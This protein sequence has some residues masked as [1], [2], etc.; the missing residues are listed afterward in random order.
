MLFRSKIYSELMDESE[1]IINKEMSNLNFS[2]LI[3]SCVFMYAVKATSIVYKSFYIDL[4]IL[5]ILIIALM[6]NNNFSFIKVINYL[7][8]SIMISGMLSTIA[9]G[10]IYL[11]KVYIKFGGIVNKSYFQPMI[12]ASSEYFCRVLFIA[13]IG[14]FIVGLIMDILVIKKRLTRR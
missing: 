9:F 3:N 2:Q 8:K 4:L 14:I 12:L 10:F 7:S 13:S 6:I 5:I 11:S 1:I